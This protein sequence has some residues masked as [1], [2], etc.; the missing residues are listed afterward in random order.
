[1]ESP[2][3][4]EHLIENVAGTVGKG[5]TVLAHLEESLIRGGFRESGPQ[6]VEMAKLL[7]NQWLWIQSNAATELRADF[8]ALAE[9]ARTTNAILL[10]IS[11]ALQQIAAI[12]ELQKERDKSTPSRP[13]PDSCGAPEDALRKAAVAETGA[14]DSLRRADSLPSE[15]VALLRTRPRGTSLTWLVAVMKRPK[16]EVH[17]ALTELLDREIV[18]CRRSSGRKLFVLRRSGE[19]RTRKK[20]RL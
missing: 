9:R 3:S 2:D 12:S 14:S 15:I 5:Q 19:W 20:G 13:W 16:K 18:V 11:Q 1:M 6:Y 7:I 4:R 10:P 8:E 17:A